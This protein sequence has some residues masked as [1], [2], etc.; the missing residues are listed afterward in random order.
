MPGFGHQSTTIDRLCRYISKATRNIG[1][2]AVRYAS[3][4]TP[5]KGTIL[6]VDDEQSICDIIT[7]ILEP[8]GFQ[9][10]TASSAE[11]ALNYFGEYSIDV[12]F[13]DIHMG[14]MDGFELLSR[15]SNI[16]NTI[17]VIVMTGFG[18]YEAVLKSLQA[19]AYDYLEKPLE[20]HSRILS[21]ARRA[22]ENAL[23]HR[24]NQML[25]AKLKTS[26]ANLAAANAQLVNLNKQLKT[27]AISDPLTEIFNRRYIDMVLKREFERYLRYSHHFSV[28]L[29]DIDHFSR[30]NEQFGHEGGDAALVQVA[31]VLQE[32]SRASDILGRYGGEEFCLIL[33]QTDRARTM[34]VAERIRKAFE[35][36]DINVQD[37]HINLSVSL[38]V[39]TTLSNNQAQ[40]EKELLN[41]CDMALYRAKELG[42]NQIEIYDDQDPYYTN[43]S[44]SARH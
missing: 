22:V 16:D 42:R 21:A 20:D 5:S 35:T 27:Q 41:R 12:V 38:G 15:V 24:D 29:L 18:G 36:T 8:E 14:G 37:Q 31:K 43:R 6:A 39:S 4:I 23:L 1:T 30:F 11:E 44:T 32:N 34:I 33:T 9:V 10:I 2:P 13:T 3:M 26:H 17:N 28:I 19:G 25:L 40:S 7:A